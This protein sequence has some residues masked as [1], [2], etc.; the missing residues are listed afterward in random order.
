MALS[1]YASD[2]TRDDAWAFGFTWH[3]AWKRWNIWSTPLSDDEYQQT[4]P[5]L[6]GDDLPDASPTTPC[7]DP[8]GTGICGQS[9]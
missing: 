6:N 7:I 8:N 2:R 9:Q 3:V 4:A 1:Y 5:D